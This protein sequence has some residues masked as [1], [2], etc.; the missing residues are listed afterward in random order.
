MLS[1]CAVQMFGIKFRRFSVWWSTFLYQEFRR[2]VLGIIRLKFERR[3]VPMVQEL[4]SAERSRFPVNLVQHR[5]P[6][7]THAMRRWRVHDSFAIGEIIMVYELRSNNKMTVITPPRIGVDSR[8]ET[9]MIW[10]GRRRF[11]TRT[12]D[13]P[14]PVKR[15][16]PNRLEQQAHYSRN[17][18][19]T[20]HTRSHNSMG[21]SLYAV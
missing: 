11:S 8:Y 2:F 21:R 14:T 19:G 7:V 15:K 1:G 12:S 10:K 16:K 3:S 9:E 5:V 17:T 13:T 6:L 18:R 20:S 4:D